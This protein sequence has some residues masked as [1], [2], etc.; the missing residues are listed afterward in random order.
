MV[1]KLLHAEGIAFF[2]AALFC[3][4]L[5]EGNWLLFIILLFTPDI[6]MLGYLKDKKLGAQLYNLGHNYVLAL[7]VI[8]FGL[9]VTGN[10][11]VTH[12]GIILFAHVALDRALGYGLKYP[13]SFKD[14]HL[15]KV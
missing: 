8:S 9:F 12:V 7:L 2:L 13:S 5:F 10:P 14:T 15:Q 3:Y 4:N 6:S 11:L 1:K